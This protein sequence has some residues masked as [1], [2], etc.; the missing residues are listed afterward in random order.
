CRSPFGLVINCRDCADA[1]FGVK[2]RENQEGRGCAAALRSG[3]KRLP[4]LLAGGTSA[5]RRKLL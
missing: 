5:A 3:A 1:G 4:R 2:P